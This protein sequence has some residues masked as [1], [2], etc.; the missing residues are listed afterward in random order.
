MSPQQR[1]GLAGAI[2][3][4]VCDLRWKRFADAAGGATIFH[5][6][7]W[8][9]LIAGRY[10]YPVAAC[11]VLDGDGEIAAGLPVALVGS[12]LTGRRLVAFPFSDVCPP[13]GAASAV[14]ELADVAEQLRSR[15]RAPLEVRGDFPGRPG[16]RYV[17]HVVALGPRVADVERGFTRSSVLRGVRRAR[18]E[19]L[20]AERRSDVEA[21]DIFYRLHVATRSRLGAPTQPRAFIRDLRHLFTEGLGFVMLVSRGTDVAAAAVFLHHGGTLTYKYGASDVNALSMRPNNLLFWEA[22]RWGCENDFATLD[23]GRSDVDQQSL[24]EFKLSWGAEELPLV[25][26]HLGAGGPRAADRGLPGRL[27]AEGIRRTPPVVS[28]LTG[29]LLYRHAG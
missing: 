15:M 10:G 20:V 14:G 24:R 6:P 4:P 25:Y 5:H 11:A 19:G 7:A 16:A 27:L 22:I 26:A 13:L 29:E 3:D 2:L 17:H 21:L 12:P 18:R 28:R 9:R 1:V 23:L 8:L